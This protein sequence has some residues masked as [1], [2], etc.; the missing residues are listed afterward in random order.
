M[1]SILQGHGCVRVEN[2]YPRD[3]LYDYKVH[4]KVISLR[5]VYEI[6][7]ERTGEQ[8]A[9]ARQTWFSVFRSTMHIEDMYGNRVLTAK[10]GFFDFTFKILDAQG[11]LVAILSRPWI[12]IF[13]NFKILYHNEV[14]KA[15]GGI[16]PWG[17]EAAT[18]TGRFAFRLDKKIFSIRDTYKITVGEFMDPLHAIT[19]ALVID[20][21]FFK[22]KGC[23]C[24]LIACLIMIPIL[25]VFF[26]IMGLFM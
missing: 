21:V 16:L 14:V 4:Q 23:G 12:A 6:F 26:I 18:P 10:G 5:P 3:S 19:S 22:G 13:K 17:F 15:Q 20:R 11:N 25:I 8:L 24:G 1:V 9:V 2:N 7:D